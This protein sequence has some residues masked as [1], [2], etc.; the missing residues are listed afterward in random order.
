MEQDGWIHCQCSG[1]RIGYNQNWVVN[2]WAIT[3]ADSVTEF[4]CPKCRSTWS[5][6]TETFTRYWTPAEPAVVAHG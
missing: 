2:Y 1:P 3:R 6:P 5:L 4:A